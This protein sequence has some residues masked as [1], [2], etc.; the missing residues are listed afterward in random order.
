MHG[1]LIS[2]QVLILSPWSTIQHWAHS[3]IESEHS[4]HVDCVVWCWDTRTLKVT[5]L[6]ACSKLCYTWWSTWTSCKCW[7]LFI[8]NWFSY[9]WE[10]L[11]RRNRTSSKDDCTGVENK[12][13]YIQEKHRVHGHSG[14]MR[15]WQGK[16]LQKY[17]CL[18][19]SFTSQEFNTFICHSVRSSVM[20]IL[21][22]LTTC[23]L[24]CFF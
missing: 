2:Q 6:Y 3:V 15:Q 18:S 16:A 12:R 17:K 9:R 20:V 8:G 24:L 11:H 7:C 23:S 10:Q 1:T 4:W 21:W 14:S 13:T 19:A 5:H 22:V